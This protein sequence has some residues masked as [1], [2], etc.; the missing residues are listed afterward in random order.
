MNRL[1]LTLFLAVCT[2]LAA[3]FGDEDDFSAS[4][5]PGVD[6][7]DHFGVDELSELLSNVHSEEDSGYPS[8]SSPVSRSASV[9]AVTTTPV[10]IAG[11]FY[12][13]SATS[14]TNLVSQLEH[15]AAFL[16]ANK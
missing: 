16:M 12:P 2:V 9:S 8:E 7:P 10:R 14:A 4:A 5:F 3:A 15:Q 1:L 11:I 13:G 6:S